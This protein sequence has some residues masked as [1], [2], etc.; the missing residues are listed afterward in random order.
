LN[1]GASRETMTA[2]PGTMVQA[3]VD[4][5]RII[6]IG[7]RAPSDEEWDQHLVDA[8]ACLTATRGVLVFSPVAGPTSR[9]RAA[10]GKHP[11]LLARP[12][13][14]V[15]ASRLTRG[16]VTAVSWLGGRPRAFSP[17]AVELAFDFLE[18]AASARLRILRANDRMRSQLESPGR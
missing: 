1:L 16:I 14:I 11:A 2:V 6:V 4:G 10:L 17:D 15:S 12:T 8:E 7:P 9:Q 5:I 18:V 13:A 3:M